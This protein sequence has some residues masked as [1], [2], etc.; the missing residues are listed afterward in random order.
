MFQRRSTHVAVRCHFGACRMPYRFRK[1][2]NT[3]RVSEKKTHWNN[4]LLEFECL[5]TLQVYKKKR[6]P[7]EINHIVKIW[8]PF[9]LHICWTVVRE[10]IMMSA[11]IRE[12]RPL[13]INHCYNLN[14]G[15]FANPTSAEHAIYTYSIHGRFSSQEQTVFPGADLCYPGARAEAPEYR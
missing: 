11:Y 6:R 2:N 5:I 4:V 14:P 13:E 12:R 10:L 9:Q 7:L 1:F 15:D 8:M 3:H